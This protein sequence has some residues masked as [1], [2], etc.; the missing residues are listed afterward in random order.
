MSKACRPLEGVKVSTYYIH[1]EPVLDAKRCLFG[2]E[3]S[4]RRDA[5]IQGGPKWPVVSVDEDVVAAVSSGGGFKRLTGKT[6]TFLTLDVRVMK[7]DLLA[8]LPKESVFQV[9]EKDAS[10]NEVLLK[11]AMLKKQA[12]RIA[13]DYTPSWRGLSPLHRIAD[14]VRIDVSPSA[15]AVAATVAL[16]KG[17]PTGLIAGRVGNRESFIRHRSLGFELFQGPFL[18]ESS[19]EGSPSISSSQEVLL[20]LCNDLRA[21]KDVGVIERA[22]KDNPKLAYGLLRLMNSAFF[23]AGRTIASIGQAIALLGYENL[24][25]WVV[26]L[27]FTVDHR[28]AQSH[29]LIEKALMRSRLMESLAKETGERALADSAFITGML[30]LM[31]ALFNIPPDEVTRKLSL[32]GEIRD[33]LERRE[34]VLGVLLA[35]AEKAD[36]QEYD[37]MDE[38]IA[39]VKLSVE[40]VLRAETDALMDSERVFD[41]E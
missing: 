6:R 12:H 38:E 35:L 20:R 32:V 17:L 10:D 25:K 41:T 36:R 7:G 39:A 24:L 27:L 13:V 9:P 5:S 37:C 3:L 29:P 21:N 18:A 19:G 16:F 22:F 11:A 15:D 1:K 8:L 23:Q 26:L 33:A 4:F 14:F 28:D 31:S 2:H 34:G 40:D 30:S